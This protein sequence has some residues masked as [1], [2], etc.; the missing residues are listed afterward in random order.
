MENVLADVV[1]ALSCDY[2][3]VIIALTTAGTTTSQKLNSNCEI[4]QLNKKAGNDLSAWPKIYRLLKQ[5]KPDILQ[6]YNLPTIEYQLIGLFVGVP[7]RVHAEHGR[8]A[9]D[10]EGKNKK[11]L[12]LR[13]LLACFIH[14]W[15]AVSQDLQQWL[16]T[17]VGIRSDAIKLI[18]NGVDTDRFSPPKSN[19]N[20][21]TGRRF[22][23]KFTKDAFV[24][25]TIGRLDPVK[26]QKILIDALASIRAAATKDSPNVVVAIVGDG[27]LKT[28]LEKRIVEKNL[29]AYVWLPGARDD[30]V[31]LLSQFDLFVL[32]S[33]AEGI[34]ISLLEA[35]SMQLPIVASSVGGIPDVVPEDC[36]MLVP[37]DNIEDLIEAIQFFSTNRPIALSNG[38]R[39]RS[40]VKKYF[41]QSRMILLYRDLYNYLDD[42]A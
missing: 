35:M 30:V 7:F 10:P 39:G 33:I 6:T 28:D 36:G 1:N 8:D 3:H 37:P 41:S 40:H 4:Y 19:T 34:P 9:S 2:H 32:P 29:E 24:V 31:S 26:N 15:I 12:L 27:A 13:K 16:L 11:Y 25:G 18:Q 42:H 22:E 17:S 20:E 5:H 23:G 14:R 38:E 21:A